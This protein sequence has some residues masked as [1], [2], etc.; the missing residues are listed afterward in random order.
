MELYFSKNACS[1]AVRI[2]IH[3]LGLPCKYEAVDIYNKKTA[4]RKDYKIINPKGN[5][6]ALVVDDGMAK[7]SPKIVRYNS[8]GD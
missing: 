6:P 3:E 8:K 2:L 1:L 4:S 5:V 7:C